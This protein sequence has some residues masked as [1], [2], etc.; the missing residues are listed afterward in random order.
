MIKK[1][2]I[3]FFEIKWLL[4]LSEKVVGITGLA[5]LAKI[6]AGIARPI[7][8]AQGRRFKLV[9]KVRLPMQVDG[10]PWIQQPGTISVTKLER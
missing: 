7:P 3:C 4:P 10:E 6:K 1:I 2:L 9:S 8:I 5:H